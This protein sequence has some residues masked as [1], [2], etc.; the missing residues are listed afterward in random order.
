[1][2]GPAETVLRRLRAT[3]PG[4]ADRAIGLIAERA[5]ERLDAPARLPASSHDQSA[6]RQASGTT[7]PSR[8]GD[9]A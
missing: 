2:Q 9:D 6:G 8:P 3:E 7:A 5:A 4:L 1:M